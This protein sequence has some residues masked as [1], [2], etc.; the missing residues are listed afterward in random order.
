MGSQLCRPATL[1]CDAQTVHS[2]RFPMY[3]VKAW[4]ILVLL[5]FID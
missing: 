5:V 3:V 1:S 4:G 2:M